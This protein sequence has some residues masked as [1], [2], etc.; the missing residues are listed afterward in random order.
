MLSDAGD[1][2]FALSPLA[3][4]IT[5]SSP[6]FEHLVRNETIKSTDLNKLLPSC[7]VTTSLTSF[8]GSSKH[9]GLG[10]VESDR[11]SPRTGVNLSTTTPQRSATS[12]LPESG[13]RR[14]TSPVRVHP[15]SGTTRLST[16]RLSEVS[17]AGSVL[18]WRN[19]S[20]ELTQPI[21]IACPPGSSTEV[22]DVSV[23]IE[24]G[25][26]QDSSLGGHTDRNYSELDA[27]VTPVGSE[28][29]NSKVFRFS[30]PVA[31]PLP[32]SPSELHPSMVIIATATTTSPAVMQSSAP[33]EADFPS[34]EVSPQQ[35][36]NPL[37]E[38][39]WK[40]QPAKDG[41][42]APTVVL[43]HTPNQQPSPSPAKFAKLTA[44]GSPNLTTSTTSPSIPGPESLG[45]S[46]AAAKDLRQSMLNQRLGSVSPTCS[47]ETED[48]I[49]GPNEDTSE[50][51]Q[52]AESPE[53]IID[54]PAGTIPESLHCNP[55]EDKGTCDS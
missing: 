14:W 45:T 34:Q 52:S 46:L 20:G 32:T 26:Y 37:T 5:S 44:A 38:W 18:P 4:D 43:V 27:L 41:D 17:G 51:A 30:V 8:Y 13:L 29:H 9:L 36:F 55:I 50:Q 2:S 49:F 16:G 53:L 12:L 25:R 40:S 54:R 22:A 15:K 35:H 33:S 42:N 21:S 23:F 19:R 24:G 7:N 6:L 3:G 48:T 28:A 10:V 11:D 31:R 39:I 47:H 1:S